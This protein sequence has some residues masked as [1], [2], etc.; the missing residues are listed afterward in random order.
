M[1]RQCGCDGTCATFDN[2]ITCA[3]GTTS[4]ERD[5]PSRSATQSPRTSTRCG[6]RAD[7]VGSSG[8]VS[9]SRPASSAARSRND[10]RSYP[11]S[12]GPISEPWIGDDHRDGMPPMPNDGTGEPAGDAAHRVRVVTGVDGSTTASA[13]D[14]ARR[15]AQIAV[16]SAPDT[17]PFASMPSGCHSSSRTFSNRSRRRWST[18]S[19]VGAIAASGSPPASATRTSSAKIAHPSPAAGSP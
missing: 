13:N 18:S 5:A 1:R 16:P 7:H 3:F 19:S 17:A 14:D 15:N 11:L 6:P 8:G 4:C 12:A 2:E 9:G 10:A